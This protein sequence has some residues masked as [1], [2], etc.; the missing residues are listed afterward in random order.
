M[1]EFN[2]EREL[3]VIA[4][5]KSFAP[6][7]PFHLDLSGL[8]PGAPLH[9]LLGDNGS[10]KSYLVQ[11]LAKAASAVGC[12]PLQLSM[13][14]RSRSGI[15]RQL[16]Y[17]DEASQSTGLASLGVLRRAVSSMEGWGARPHLA[18]L[19]EPDIGLSE[20]Y[21]YPMGQRIAN[22]ACTRPAGTKAV[23]LVT[24]SRAL[25][26]GVLS[27]Q[28]TGQGDTSVI[29]LGTRYR[30]LGDFLDEPCYATLSELAKLEEKN[31]AVRAAVREARGL[32]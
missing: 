10:G 16:M 23:V 20:R 9:F 6:D 5:H 8:R 15:E 30:S 28:P 25:V 13:G 3:H 12:C 18:L 1:T 17:G 22:F 32:A 27:E 21:A 2:L 24:H 7:G 26:R 4:T 11:R 29:L 19:D 14:Y 31:S